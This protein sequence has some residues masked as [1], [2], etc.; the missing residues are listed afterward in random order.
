MNRPPRTHVIACGVLAIDIRQAAER[1]GLDVTTEFL[2]AGLHERPGELRRRLQAAIDQASAAGGCDR[3]AI[4]Y[5]VCGRGTVGIRARGVPLVLP[6]AHDC[7]ALFLGSDAAYR[8]EFARCPGTYYISAGWHEAKVQPRTQAGK[9]ARKKRAAASFEALAAKYGAENAQAII[10]FLNSWQRNYTRAAFIDTSSGDR[11]RYASYARAMADELGWQYEELAGSTALVEKILTAEATSGEVLVVPPRCATAFDP[12]EAALKAVPAWGLAGA[13]TEAER[14]PQAAL[15]APAQAPPSRSRTGLGID[16]GGTYTDVVVYGFAGEAVLAKSKALTTKWDFALGIDNALARLAPELL[17]AVDLVAV[18]T[19]LATNA[20]VEGQG[21]KVGLLVMPPYGR[22][23]PA[24]VPHEPKAAITGSMEIDGTELRPVDPEQV[25]RVAREMVERQGV[26]AFAVSGFGGTVNP[27]HELEAKALIRHATGCTVTCGHEL[28]ELLDVRTRA[29]TA[30]LNAR[31]IPRLERLIRDVEAALHARRIAAPIMVVKGDGSLMSAHLARE[32]P[33]ETILSG[34]AASVAGARRLT[35]RRDA[36]VVDMGGTTTDT[37]ALKDGAARTCASGARVGRWQTHVRALDMRTTGLGGDS[38]IAHERQQL[39]IGPLRVGPVAW[40]AAHQAATSAALDYLE[41][42]LDDVDGSTRPMELVALTGYADGFEPRDDERDILDALR[43]HPHSLAQLAER[44][45]APHWSLLRLD[46]LEAHH[47]VQRC[48]LTPTDLLHAAGRFERWDT[49]AA[50]RLHEMVSHVAGAEPDD[51]HERVMGQLVRRLAVELLKKQLDEQTEADAIDH[52]PACQ[53][54]LDN[55]L[56][57][58]SADYTVGLTLH[59]PVVG[60]GAPVHFFLPRAAQLLGAEAVIPAH[61][62]VANAIGAITSWVVV[63]RQVHIR[64][65]AAGGYLVQGLPE[66]RGFQS[67]D[68]ADAHARGEL[69]RIVLELGRAAGTTAS[70]VGLHAADRI[71]RAADGTEL[72]LER[73]LRAELA[74]PPDA[75]PG[76]PS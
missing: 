28:S 43:E 7:I 4:G 44:T 3:I 6:K 71:A 19:T 58:G 66:A 63:R 33:I 17:E 27:R 59:R 45:A 72:F 34:P 54:L 25:R 10:D 38:L 47:I 46:R 52:C 60:L 35:G 11:E 14:E 36:L 13:H 16:A 24:D 76:A 62:D 42:H 41:A 8:R 64:P 22:F 61:A 56:A 29:D 12:I 1:L 74:G 20:I 31:I 65:D 30:V 67:F 37:A 50:R 39:L 55:L 51:F 48:G 53:T 73:T 75:P 2:E 15:V 32:R 70:S 21:Q 18:S 69:E 9:E 49:R 23:D 5:G 57:G 26:E 40:L 68:A